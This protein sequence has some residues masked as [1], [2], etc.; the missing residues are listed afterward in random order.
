MKLF[1]QDL[2]MQYMVKYVTDKNK[3]PQILKGFIPI[4]W[5]T[6]REDYVEILLCRMVQKYLSLPHN[7]LHLVLKTNA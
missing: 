5:I 3:M 6:F 1:A 4:S 2:R 7:A